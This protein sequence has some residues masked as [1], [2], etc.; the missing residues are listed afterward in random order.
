MKLNLLI[1]FALN[2]KNKAQFKNIFGLMDSLIIFKF[3][4]QN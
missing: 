1:L 2:S 4:N 3:A